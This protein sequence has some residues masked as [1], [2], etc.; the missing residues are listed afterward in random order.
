MN[1]RRVRRQSAERVKRLAKQKDEENGVHMCYL[2][3]DGAT[4]LLGILVIFRAA[5]NIPNKLKDEFRGGIYKTLTLAPWV[6]KALFKDE[7]NRRLRICITLE[8]LLC[9]ERL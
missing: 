1:K 6:P 9:C 4:L 5:G 7:K 2:L 8:A 3:N